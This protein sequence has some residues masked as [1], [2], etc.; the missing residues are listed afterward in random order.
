MS[1]APH[2]SAR[3][4]RTPLRGVLALACLALGSGVLRAAEAGDAPRT[5]LL[6]HQFRE[7]ETEC[8]R[9]TLAGKGTLAPQDTRLALPLRLAQELEVRRQVKR[10][11]QDGTA[12]LSLAYLPRR[13][14]VNGT[15]INDTRAL[16]SEAVVT[17]MGALREWRPL[18]AVANQ[19]APWALG[20]AAL[21]ASLPWLAFPEHPVAAAA[22]WPAAAPTDPGTWHR[23]TLAALEGAPERAV[24]HLK[25]AFALPLHLRASEAA[26]SPSALTGRHAGD[27]TLRFDVA[28]GRLLHATGNIDV[29]ATL[30]QPDGTLADLR[31]RLSVQLQY[32]APSAPR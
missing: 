22:S 3:P 24:A 6:R 28:A 29:T 17:P 9:L 31:L 16:H 27:L 11:R 23:T 2:H 7:G 10:V 1:P 20:S 21:A 14:E 12:E 5:V 18:P 19:P 26:G 13:L 30:V 32:L 25:Q 15:R 4:W 8:Y